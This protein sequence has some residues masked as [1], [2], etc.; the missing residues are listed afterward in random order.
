MIGPF[1]A[2]GRLLP[3]EKAL[4]ILGLAFLVAFAFLWAW[5]ALL[6]YRILFASW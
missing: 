5:T 2:W 6:A 1:D 3:I 4:I